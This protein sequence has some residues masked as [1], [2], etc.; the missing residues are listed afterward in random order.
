M[1]EPRGRPKRG[2]PT[3][4]KKEYAQEAYERSL[5]GYTLANLG[6]HFGVNKATICRWQNKYCEFRDAIKRGGLRADAQIVQALYRRAIGY[7][8]P[9]VKIFCYEGRIIQCVY[10]ARYPPDFHSIRFW[11]MNRQPALWRDKVEAN[12]NEQAMEFLK[13]LEEQIRNGPAKQPSDHLKERLE[14]VTPS[15]TLA[16]GGA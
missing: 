14:L 8:H 1:A 3:E 2:R 15:E 10:T 11:L 9:A 13:E 4:Y 7:A 12:S 16:G 6:A 5:L